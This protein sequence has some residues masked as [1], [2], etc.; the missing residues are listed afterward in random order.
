M[1][2]RYKY[3][4]NCEFYH[5]VGLDEDSQGMC[6]GNPPSAIGPSGEGDGIPRVSFSGDCGAWRVHPEKVD[7]PNQDRQNP[8]QKRIDSGIKEL[9]HIAKRYVERE[10]EFRNPSFEDIEHDPT[11]RMFRHI[12]GILDGTEEPEEPKQI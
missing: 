12:I 6:R 5:P 4:W 10:F 1:A 11:V 9:Q 3:C 2:D 8:L 7:I